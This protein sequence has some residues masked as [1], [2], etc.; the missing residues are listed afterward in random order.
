LECGDALGGAAGYFM[1]QPQHMPL[2]LSVMPHGMYVGL[3]K[4]L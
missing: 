4:S 3:K 2:V 1:H